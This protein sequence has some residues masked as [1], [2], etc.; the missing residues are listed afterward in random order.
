MKISLLMIK[1]NRCDYLNKRACDSERLLKI[2]TDKL[3][4]SVCLHSDFFVIVAVYFLILFTVFL[5]YPS[6][7]RLFEK[8]KKWGA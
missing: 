5:F 4:N 8:K 1:R 3:G 7:K 2:Q 6:P